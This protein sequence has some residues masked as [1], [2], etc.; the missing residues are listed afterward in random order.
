MINRKEAKASQYHVT[1]PKNFKRGRGSSTSTTA[2][3]RRKK[4]RARAYMIALP[5]PHSPLDFNIAEKI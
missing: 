5:S 1:N 3:G 4:S 2:R